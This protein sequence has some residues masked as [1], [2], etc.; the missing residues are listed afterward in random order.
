MAICLLIFLLCLCF[1]EISGSGIKSGLNLIAN[2]VLPALYPFILLA[3]FF[4]YLADRKS[5]YQFLPIFI[6]FLSGYPL[7]AKVA[8]DYD[9]SGKS[10]FT[11]ALLLICNNPSPA[12]MISFIG[13][14]CL[15]APALGVRMYIAVIAGNLL[16]GLLCMAYDS[17]RFSRG[18]MH[19]CSTASRETASKGL[20][21]QVI[22]DTFTVILNVSSY[23]LI[24]SVAAA[25][26]Q[27]LNFLPPIYQGLLAGILE[28]T[29]GIQ[30]L[31]TQPLPLNT[32]LL[33]T[34]GL[35]SFGGL[36]VLAQTNSMIA[37]SSLSIKKYI[38]EKAI[39]STIAVSVMYMLLS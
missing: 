14:H 8:A 28:M 7:G 19:L 26:I 11:Q 16:T 18:E 21:D 2:Q 35:V 36:S 12:Y 13:L 33:L 38:T 4:K 37:G 1:P 39:A 34:T 22:H 17:R 6:G 27:K 31:N 5:K 3:T 24:F 29:T 9:L 30:M 15:K 23:I 25:F 32:K 20:L 10:R